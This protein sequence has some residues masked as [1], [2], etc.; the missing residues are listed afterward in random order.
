MTVKEKAAVGTGGNTVVSNHSESTPAN[1][2]VQTAVAIYL[3]VSL[4]P[5][6]AGIGASFARIT[7]GTTREIGIKLYSPTLLV[8]RSLAKGDLLGTKFFASLLLCEFLAQ[9]HR[10]PEISAIQRALVNQV[11]SKAF[12]GNKVF[13]HLASELARSKYGSCLAKLPI[14]GAKPQAGP[15]WWLSLPVAGLS[16]AA[17]QLWQWNPALKRPD[18]NGRPKGG[19]R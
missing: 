12:R 17:S 15:Q 6:K 18:K 14:F 16:G 5:N 9:H 1:A 7:D 11:S 19:E 4:E 3:E 8:G 10:L 2:P 13:T